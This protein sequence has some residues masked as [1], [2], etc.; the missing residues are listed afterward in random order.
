MP[1]GQPTRSPQ[2]LLKQ[3]SQAQARLFEFLDG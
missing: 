2:S 1:A 3:K